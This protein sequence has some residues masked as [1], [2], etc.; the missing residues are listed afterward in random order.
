MAVQKDI[1]GYEEGKRKEL[2][3]DFYFKVNPPTANLIL[4]EAVRQFPTGRS[5]TCGWLPA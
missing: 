4:K 3:V 5:W 1:K 2:S